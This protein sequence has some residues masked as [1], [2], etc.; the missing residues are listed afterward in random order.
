M[1]TTTIPLSARLL[2]NYL[3]ANGGQEV[4]TFDEISEARSYAESLREIHRD[5][6]NSLISVEQSY[7]KVTT[8]VLQ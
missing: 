5:Y 3:K 8:K 7:N 1:K 4:S 2:I 6:L